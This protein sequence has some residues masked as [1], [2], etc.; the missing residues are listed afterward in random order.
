M[1]ALTEVA[2]DGCKE[3][4]GIHFA[5]PSRWLVGVCTDVAVTR[6]LWMGLIQGIPQAGIGSQELPLY[7]SG[8]YFRAAILM[9]P[10]IRVA[11]AW[12]QF[13]VEDPEQAKLMDYPKFVSLVVAGKMGK[14]EQGYE[15]MTLRQVD[16][17]AVSDDYE[18]D[19]IFRFDRTDQW[20]PMLQRRFGLGA[21]E[22]I[23]VPPDVP[24]LPKSLKLG[25]RKVYAPDYSLLADIGEAPFLVI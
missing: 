17:F 9:D 3:V 22:F 7:R 6:R 8:S 2:G 21:F 25:L 18:V 19:A 10:E 15:L 13:K 12:E 11:Y 5:L 4:G 20:M 23:Y 24:E 1:M 16:Y 14:G